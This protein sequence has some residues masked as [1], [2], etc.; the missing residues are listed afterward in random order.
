MPLHPR[1]LALLVLLAPACG[2]RLPTLR[3]PNVTPPSPAPPSAVAADLDGDGVVDASDSCPDAPGPG[4]AGCPDLDGDDDGILD[5]NDKCPVEPENYNGYD[6]EDGC[7]DDIP[8]S[9]I[10]CKPS[11]ITG[12]N[13]GGVREAIRA[14]PD[15]PARIEARLLAAERRARRRSQAQALAT[16]GQLPSTAHAIVKRVAVILHDFPTIR[17][18]ITGHSDSQEGRS[19]EDRRALSQARAVAVRDYLVK[20]GIAADRL[21][22]RAAGSSDPIDTNETALGR[23]RNRRINF[24]VIPE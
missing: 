21:E 10:T 1:V 23:A 16:A 15:R 5:A 14:D 24:E 2:P 22:L 19:D 13:L 6:D 20:L 4:P 7:R 3:S 11:G 12:V 17:F 8:E 18:E 9:A